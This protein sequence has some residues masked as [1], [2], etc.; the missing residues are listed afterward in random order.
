M[1]MFLT[2]MGMNSKIVVSGDATQVDLPPHVRS[3][4]VDA[5][6]RLRGIK[7]VVEVHLTGRDIVRHRLVQEIVRAYDEDP[8]RKEIR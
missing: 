3:G 4:L 7:G 8:K 1:K 6:G 2:R 5:V